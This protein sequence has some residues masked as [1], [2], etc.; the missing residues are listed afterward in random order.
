MMRV[1]VIMRSKNDIVMKAKFE[2]KYYDCNN[3][4]G[5]MINI[6]LPTT[7]TIRDEN[8]I[9]FNQVFDCNWGVYNNGYREAVTAIESCDNYV[10][11]KN[12]VR[13]YINNE[14]YKI[15]RIKPED[16]NIEVVI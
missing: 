6:S 10:V 2:I 7:F 3:I 11:L 9:V 16:E 14:M 12:K 4:Y 8:I 13:D 15:R 5:A 1:T